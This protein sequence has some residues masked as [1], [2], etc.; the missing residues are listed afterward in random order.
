MEDAALVA[1]V[2]A[3]KGGTVGSQADE[4]VD[5]ARGYVSKKADLDGSGG[6]VPDVDVKVHL[7]RDALGATSLVV[8]GQWSPFHDLTGVKV[9]Q[10]DSTFLNP[11]C[12]SCIAP[13]ER[14]FECTYLLN[15]RKYFS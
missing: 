8:E 10:L 6:S 7:L 14:C 4:V 2:V 3:V 15:R 11:L 5:G 13:R 9:R 1:A 12:M